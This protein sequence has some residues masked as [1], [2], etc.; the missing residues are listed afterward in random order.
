M[1]NPDVSGEI[2]PLCSRSPTGDGTGKAG[3][4]VGERA[5]VRGPLMALLNVAWT[6]VH[7]CMRNPPFAWTRAHATS[8]H[9]LREAVGLLGL[10]SP[11][12]LNPLSRSHH[13]RAS[14]ADRGG[15]GAGIPRISRWLVV[16]ARVIAKLLVGSLLSHSSIACAQNFSACE[17][18]LQNSAE[19]ARE[20]SARYWSGQPLPGRWSTP[21]PV[22][23][24]QRT[25]PASGLTCFQIQGGE[26]FGWRM[27]LRGDRE[28]VLQDV[29]PHEVDHAVRASLCR[30]PLP[31]WLDE[32]CASL[33]ESESS[34]EQLRRLR[35][36]SPQRLI[37]ASTIDQLSYPTSSTETTQLYAEGF[38]LVEYLL[39][40]GTP[41]Q[42]LQ[43]QQASDP[44]SRSLVKVY[45]AE[46]PRILSDWDRWEQKRLVQGT[47]CDC[48]N[49]PWHRS[50]QPSAISG[51]P[52]AV[53]ATGD[54]KP[55]LTI[56]TADWCGPCQQ[57]HRDLAN[58]SDFR[59][60]LESKFQLR[61]I[62]VDQSRGAAQQARV[63]RVP[64]FQA[65]DRR[66]E[67]YLGPE[68]LLREL[69]LEE[70]VTPA[71]VPSDSWP[72]IPIPAPKIVL[73]DVPRLLPSLP[74]EIQPETKPP[75]AQPI[76]LSSTSLWSRILGLAPTAITILSSLG[77]ISG[78][79]LTGGVGGVALML[80]LK[81]LQ[82]RATRASPG[83]P[84]ALNGGVVSPTH[85]PFPRQLDE[86][87]ELL[88][89]RQSEGRVATLDALRGMFLDDEL[90]K[91]KD[92][93]DPNRAALVRQIRAAV[94]SRVDEV[95]PLTTKG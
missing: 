95:A 23:W 54:V 44:P 59:T 19:A 77:I 90:D 67:G 85:A 93:P 61:E 41:Q 1:S 45:R 83:K 37:N 36:N 60:R 28:A 11:P 10:S 22:D 78:T 66:V 18:E 55:T 4:I 72:L 3:V 32:G 31:R 25:G 17:P 9:A 52:R 64:Q 15:E 53:P 29:I 13:F 79:A 14:Y 74:P 33:F 26:V 24:S 7:A 40:K 65:S 49:C 75:A 30:R 89:L 43:V 2:L 42:L 71:I 50:R 68:W 94:D 87:G 16:I 81:L 56:W 57:F 8:I 73:P 47:R 21:C 92:D 82:R 35:L 62:D 84:P 38:S 88:G 27:T 6:L 91:L 46:V 12:H 63:T 51:Q 39:S 48:V 76:P 69:G 34:H 58:N 86:A 20:R 80:I 70:T 5:G